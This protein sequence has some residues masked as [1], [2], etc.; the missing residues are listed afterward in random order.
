VPPVT[1]AGQEEARYPNVVFR[2]RMV[3]LSQTPVDE[4]QFP[5]LMI[6]HNV[7]RLHISVHDALAVTEVERLEE[8]VDVESDVQVVELGIECPEVGVVD[9][10]EDERRGLALGIPNDVQERNNVGSPGQVLE[11]LDFA[12]DLLLLNRL[13][14]LD[15]AL[16]IVDHVDTLE[17]L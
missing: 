17:Y 10:L 16:L 8:F 6:D 5:V 12:L 11:D 3:E 15:D 1:D 14:N 4:A 7:M 13:E 2:A 9:I